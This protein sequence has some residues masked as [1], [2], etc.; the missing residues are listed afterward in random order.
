MPRQF[1]T[2]RPDFFR[3]RPSIVLQVGML[4]FF[5]FKQVAGDKEAGVEGTR[6]G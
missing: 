5:F 1:L 6:T 4:F 3:S 2:R